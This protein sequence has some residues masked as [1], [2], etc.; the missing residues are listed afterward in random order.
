MPTRIAPWIIKHHD[1][2]V[3]VKKQKVE[4]ETSTFLYVVLSSDY[5]ISN[6]ST[7]N[8]KVLNGGIDAPAPRSP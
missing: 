5:K 6:N 4:A 8:T 3:I 7:S 1:D 2:L